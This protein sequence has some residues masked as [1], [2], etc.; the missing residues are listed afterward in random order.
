MMQDTQ[1]GSVAGSRRIADGSAAAPLVHA[2]EDHGMAVVIMG[3]AGTGKTTL[4]QEM[5]RE[6]G[7]P[8]AEA[9]DFHPKAN[10]EKMASGKPL[11]DDD[12]WPWLRSLRDWMQQQTP[13][14]ENVVV[15]CSALKRSYR[16]VLRE[17]ACDVFFVELDLDEDALR[18]RMEERSHFMPVSLLRSQLDTLQPLESSERGMR[19]TAQSSP[20]ELSHAVLHRLEDEGCVIERKD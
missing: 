18:K 7:W 11:N 15:T 20:E 2:D 5:V 14:G 8:Y 16:D 10:I 17:A 3:V 13:A 19:L 6:L 1:V 4:A 12:R 9:D